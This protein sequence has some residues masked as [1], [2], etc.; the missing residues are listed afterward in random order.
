[1]NIE[2]KNRIKL[3]DKA[4]GGKDS[5]VLDQ[6]IHTSKI[7]SVGNNDYNFIDNNIVEEVVRHQ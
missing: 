4:K 5:N 1:M 7:S 2:E 3:V 6:N